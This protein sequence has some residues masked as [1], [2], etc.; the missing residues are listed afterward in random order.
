MF[1]NRDE[2]ISR[3]APSDSAVWNDGA[4]RR[5]PRNWFRIVR[6]FLYAL[7]GLLAA[8][9]AL[10]ATAL[11]LDHSASPVLRASVVTEIA[12]QPPPPPPVLP[13]APAPAPVAASPP[14]PAVVIAAP[15]PPPAAAE[16]AAPAPPPAPGAPAGADTG[17][18]DAERTIQALSQHPAAPARPAPPPATPPR[19]AAAV[20][21]TG[22][23]ANAPALPPAVPDA[24]RPRV[25]LH[26]PAG[27]PGA[28]QQVS[29]LAQRLLFS[30]FTYADTR[31][32]ANGPTD[33]VIR[34]FHPEDEA[35][36][37]RLATL[38]SD[39]Q[40]SFQVQDASAHAG[41]AKPGTL[42][43]WVGR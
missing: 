27:S 10:A 21:V 32:A 19:A 13:P 28:L 37:L 33:P 40:A 2:R 24:P 34:Y 6:V 35:A 18:A 42:E 25:Y 41:R 15:A 38:L 7:T 1:I 8:V 30:D 9:A 39:G 22:L 36:A 43:V 3:A 16:V 26:Y 31:S 14:L 23:A 4:P 17:W 29:D 5:V 20:T 12:A 11:F